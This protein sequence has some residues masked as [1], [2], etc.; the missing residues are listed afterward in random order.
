MNKSM[1]LL[2]GLLLTCDV[3]AATYTNARG[4]IA[5]N[6]EITVP[7]IP[8]T[9]RQ[10]ILLFTAATHTVANI[11]QS[12]GAIDVSKQRVSPTEFNVRDGADVEILF[13]DA[14]A[15]DHFGKK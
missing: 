5:W 2:S 7:E 12:A 4:E 3:F 11:T 13:G 15:S 6:A 1:L 8:L 10:E 9:Y 14:V